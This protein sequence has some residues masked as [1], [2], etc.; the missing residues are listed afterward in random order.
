VKA[1]ASIE[2]LLQEIAERF[3]D[4]THGVCFVT[5]APLTAEDVSD[6]T[7]K[8]MAK[9][10]AEVEIAIRHRLENA[11]TEGELP[12]TVSPAGLARFLRRSDPGACPASPA[13]RN[14]KAT[15]TRR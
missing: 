8:L 9:R 1:R 6:D 2:Q 5:Q 14:A 7:P 10:R 3:T 11:V 15:S 4:K 12:A 13:W